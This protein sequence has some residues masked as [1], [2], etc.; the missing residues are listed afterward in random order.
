MDIFSHAIAGA[1]VGLAFGNP[2]LGA[3][4]GIAPDLVLGLRRR[5]LP[6]QLYNATHSVL[7]IIAVGLPIWLIFGTPIPLLALLSHLLLDLPTH[8]KEWAPTLFYPLSETRY[9]YGEEWEW[10]SE[11]WYV[12]LCF[13][14]IWS[15]AWF[16]LAFLTGFR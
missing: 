1:S 2:W 5:P 12:G 15:A 14:I 3:A 7:S 10:F 9:V 13:T 6:T 4:M 11:S 16:A 8:G